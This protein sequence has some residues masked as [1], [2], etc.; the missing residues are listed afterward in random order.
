MANISFFRIQL[1]LSLAWLPQPTKHL[2]PGY[3]PYAILPFFPSPPSLSPICNYCIYLFL[4]WCPRQDINSRTT[5]TYVPG[6]HGISQ[7]LASGPCSILICWMSEFDFLFFSFDYFP[8]KPINEEM[9]SK[10]NKQEM[11]LVQITPLERGDPE[12]HPLP[13][14]QSPQQTFSSRWNWQIW[15]CSP[16][17]AGGANDKWGGQKAAVGGKSKGM[18]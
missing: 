8:F 7:L 17:S 6:L 2:A 4:A 15:I 10:R 16:L 14:P 3:L 18:Q 13:P 11:T 5:G 9:A 1:T 12:T